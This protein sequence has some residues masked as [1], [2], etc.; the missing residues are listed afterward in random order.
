M[1]R[2]MRLRVPKTSSSLVKGHLDRPGRAA[3]GTRLVLAFRRRTASRCCAP[4][5]RSGAA[6]RWRRCLGSGRTL[7]R[8]AAGM[9]K[10]ALLDAWAEREPAGAMR[11]RRAS[12]GQPEQGFA[13][14]VV[15]QLL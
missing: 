3:E 9:G 4:R 2:A 10:T 12:A 11:V 8:G 14:A 1:G 7:V 13:F 5:W 6:P 15:R